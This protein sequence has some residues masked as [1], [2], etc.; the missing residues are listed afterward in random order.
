MAN[1]YER[2]ETRL[3]TTDEKGHRVYLYPEDIKGFWRKWRTQVYWTLIAIY[4]ILPWIHIGGKQ[5]ILLNIGDREFTFFAHTF[6]GHDAPLLIFILLGVPLVIGFIT[7]LYGRV[8]CGWAC[9]QTVFIDAI[10]SKLEKL[11]EGKARQREKLDK[12]PWTLKKFSLKSLKWFLF[13]I[14]SLHIAHSFIGYFIGTRELVQITLSPPWENPTVF[15]ATMLVSGITLFDFGWFREQFCIIMCPYGRFQSVMMDENS[16]TVAYDPNRGEPRRSPQIPREQEGDCINCFHCV[17]ACPTGIDIRQGVQ[18]L[19]CIACTNCIDA[20]DEIMEKVGRPKGLIR[21]ATQNE[22]DGKKESKFTWRS[23]V[24]L[25]LITILVSAFT[26]NIA[27]KDSMKVILLHTGGKPFVKMTRQGQTKITNHKNL[28]IDYRSDGSRKLGF[29]IR[30]KALRD[31]VQIVTPRNPWS[32]E[33]GH[34][35]APLFF[36]F[37]EEILKEGN[38][39]IHFEVYGPDKP[40]RVY[41]TLEV[42]LVGPFN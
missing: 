23:A 37:P 13:S 27:I 30:E 15:F 26:Y 5:S 40:Q 33:R 22:L 16:M 25:G 17:K 12:S 19:E 4:L 41:K 10:F 31:K 39:R 38:R 8:W 34:N 2:H 14:A 9:P 29:R 20:C 36:R 18:Q 35:K 11:V 32:V 3:A 1:K 6:Y 21:Y 42:N 28:T 24:Y 7:S